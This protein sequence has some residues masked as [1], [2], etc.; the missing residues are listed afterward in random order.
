MAPPRLAVETTGRRFQSPFFD[1]SFAPGPGV[2]SG[3]RSIVQR[4]EKRHCVAGA[5][6]G[7]HRERNHAN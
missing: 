1:G 2:F 4:R 7:K 3:V 5:W 6:D